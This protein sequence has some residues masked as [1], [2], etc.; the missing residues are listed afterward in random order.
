MQCYIFYSRNQTVLFLILLTYRIGKT[1]EATKKQKIETPPM[2]KITLRN[3]TK[4][5]NNSMLV[6]LEK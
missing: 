3:S 6:E 4:E 2:P 5:P 1:L